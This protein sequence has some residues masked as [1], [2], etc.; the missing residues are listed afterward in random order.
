MGVIFKRA[1]LKHIEASLFSH[2]H[3]FFFFFFY[4]ERG[5]GITEDRM[6]WWISVSAKSTV[7]VMEM[8]LVLISKVVK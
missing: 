7:I 5:E 4:G 2:I 3:S 8:S 1:I 6:V